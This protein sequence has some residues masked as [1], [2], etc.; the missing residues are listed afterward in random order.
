MKIALIDRGFAFNS[1]FILLYESLLSRLKNDGH[2]YYYLTEKPDFDFDVILVDSLDI[3]LNYFHSINEL[4][5]RQ[6]FLDSLKVK[7]VIQIKHDAK[8][9]DPKWE[10]SIEEVKLLDSFT[11]SFVHLSEY[12]KSLY[13]TKFSDKEHEVINHP[14]YSEIPDS[15]S[16]ERARKI[17][18]I[19]NEEVVF[20]FFG[21]PRNCK[22][23]SWLLNYFSKIPIKKKRL[24]ANRNLLAGTFIQRQIL[25]FKLLM[26]PNVNQYNERTP[27]DRIQLYMRAS[28]FGIIPRN[29]SSTL[30]SGIFFL[31]TRFSLPVIIPAKSILTKVLKQFDVITE[32]DFDYNK[33]ELY[34]SQAKNNYKKINQ[35]EFSVQ[36][37]SDQLYNIIWKIGQTT[38][39]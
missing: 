32:R 39:E 28:D 20:V 35:K 1:A 14:N 34:L 23:V 6:L 5:E 22:E 33:H 2:E 16:K 24:I 12:S 8:S 19:P 17:L 3:Y 36:F 10:N 30:N 26:N 15:I 25:R 9:H 18:E 38:Q 37:V 31:K 29:S 13:N 27:D 4:S 11:N 7:K 21:T